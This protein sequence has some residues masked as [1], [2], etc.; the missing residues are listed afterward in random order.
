M[1]ETLGE[2]GIPAAAFHLTWS[3]ASVYDS[4][5]QYS[6]L[7][8]C[9]TGTQQ[10]NRNT[11]NEKKKLNRNEP[12]S[13]TWFKK[14]INSFFFC[15]QSGTLSCVHFQSKLWNMKTVQIQRC[16][17]FRSAGNCLFDVKQFVLDDILFSV[18]VFSKYQVI[19]IVGFPSNSYRIWFFWLNNN[20]NDN[21][22]ASRL[23][24]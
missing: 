18:F 8:L 12:N 4:A 11:G 20:R 16:F 2:N 7:F 15:S 1:A 23:Y 3:I 14:P 24:I 19:S 6:R 10:H 9:W 21:D 13:K 5:D 17:C 22:P